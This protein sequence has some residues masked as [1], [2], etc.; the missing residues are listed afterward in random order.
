MTSTLV[1][2]SP[3]LELH[4]RKTAYTAELA[5]IRRKDIARA[6][7]KGA[8]LGEMISAGLPIP[9]G[10]VVTTEACMEFY[11]Q[12]RISPRIADELRNL[13]PD[14]T[15]ALST[16]SANLTKILLDGIMPDSVHLEIEEAY[17]A[18]T[19]TANRVAV[20]SS[21]TAED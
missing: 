14:N 1:P 13:D 10:F 15:A 4:A 20:R 2:Q 5:N 16:A 21:A 19:S 8:N 12:N 17:D 6:G 11:R 18:L 9:P 3:S 7:G